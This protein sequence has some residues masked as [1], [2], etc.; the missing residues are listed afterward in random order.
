MDCA[1]ILVEV[2]EQRLLR[3]FAV[4]STCPLI[5]TREFSFGTETDIRISVSG[6]LLESIVADRSQLFPRSAPEG[7]RGKSP[8][9]AL[10]A[11]SLSRDVAFN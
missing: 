2:S 11:R 6:Q 7:T 3:R 4:T 5:P 10:H 9:S 8:G 1:M